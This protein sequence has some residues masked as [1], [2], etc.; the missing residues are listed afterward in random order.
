[1]KKTIWQKL[2]SR[3]F[4]I[5][6]AGLISGAALIINGNVEEGVTSIVASVVAYLVAEGIIDA[7]AVNKQ[8]TETLEE[9]EGD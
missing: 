6:V 9:I 2:T 7:A 3:K 1:M 8:T 4:L 5:A